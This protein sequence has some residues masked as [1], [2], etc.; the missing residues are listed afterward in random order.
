MSAHVTELRVRWP[1]CDPAGIVYFANYLMYFELGTLEYLRARGASW[2]AIRRRYG[3]RG[4]PRVEAH[5]RFRASARYDDL[6][7]VQTRVS[8]V[9]R[10]IITFGCTIYRQS[11]GTLLAE[12]H[13]KV[14]LT[15]AEGRAAVLPAELVEWLRGD[16]PL[17]ALPAVGPLTPPAPTLD[18]D[19]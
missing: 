5:A 13:L 3:F 16:A 18:G 6:L 9:S 10:K 14:A 12:G 19:R 8:D 2:E 15:N 11:D 7:A 17:D 4:A 1:E